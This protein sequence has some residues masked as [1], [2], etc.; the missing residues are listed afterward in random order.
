M[1]SEIESDRLAT[2]V[3]DPKGFGVL[4]DGPGR[5]EAAAGHCP[6]RAKC[7]RAR[8]IAGAVRVLDGL[9]RGKGREPKSGAFP[10]LIGPAVVILMSALTATTGPWWGGTMIWIMFGVGAALG[11][12][13]GVAIG[14]CVAALIIGWWDRDADR[15]VRREGS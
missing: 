3:L 4:D 15:T 9:G 12:G 7:S 14:G 11:V 1:V 8:I 13:I 10:H 5:R 6:I 2:S